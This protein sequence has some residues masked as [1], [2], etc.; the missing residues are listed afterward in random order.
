M[1]KLIS[2]L[3]PII[4]FF[5]C[6]DDLPT[7]PAPESGEATSAYFSRPIEVS[8]KFQKGA[9]FVV[10]VSGEVSILDFHTHRP[11]VSGVSQRLK[12]LAPVDAATPGKSGRVV[13]QRRGEDAN[14]VQSFAVD[15]YVLGVDVD[16]A[17]GELAQRRDRVHLLPDEV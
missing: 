6:G 5:G 13:L 8:G 3:C 7:D 16:Q 1:K 2:T 10:S 12:K 4:L 14:R 9:T 11:A 15:R 17:V